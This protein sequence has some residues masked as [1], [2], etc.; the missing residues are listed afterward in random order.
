MFEDCQSLQSVEFPRS[1]TTIGIGVLSFGVGIRTLRMNRV[2]WDSIRATL[3][4]NP[5]TSHRVTSY[6]DPN[7]YLVMRSNSS[8][9]VVD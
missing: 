8:G 2:L 1:L 4:E 5:S 7:L 3:P 6:D 9:I